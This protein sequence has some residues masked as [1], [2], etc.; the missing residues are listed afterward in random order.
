MSFGKGLNESSGVKNVLILYRELAGYVVACIN[1]LCDEYQVQADV[2][3]YPLNSDAPFQFEFSP[4]VNLENRKDHNVDSLRHKIKQK[5]YDLILVSGWADKDYLSALGAS[6]DAVKVVGFDT[7][8]YGT[9][10]Q[11]LAA[12]Y[13]RLFIKPLF[14][15]AFVPGPEQSL[16][17]RCFGFRENQIL[18]GIYACDVPRF[19]AIANERKGHIENDI[20]KLLYVGRYAPEKFVVELCE[21]MIGLYNEGIQDWQLQCIGTGPL[22]ASRIEHPSIAHM[23]FQQPAQLAGLMRDGDAFIL[24]STFEPWGVVVHEFAA[25]G[26][27]LILSSNV[28]ARHAF[29]IDG[30]NG[31]IF[32]SGDRDAMKSAIRN[33]MQTP[34][35]KLFEMGGLSSNLAKKITPDSWSK[36]LLELM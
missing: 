5:K 8:W 26:Y 14:D 11:W 29:L 36:T 21:T 24:P 30:Q 33:M 23:G 22:F 1:H 19:N 25:A 3:A 16:L 27:P 31:F 28:G 6:K 35:N 32:Q 13:A 17:A 9:P 10:K 4:G 34:Q 15:F 18:K 2:I 12:V 7:W 20:K